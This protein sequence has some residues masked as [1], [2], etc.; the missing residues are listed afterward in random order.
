MSEDLDK[1]FSQLKNRAF[2]DNRNEVTREELERFRAKANQPVIMPA[3]ENDRLAER[4]FNEVY[5][6]SENEERIRSE[7]EKM[8]QTILN[9][10]R[11]LATT[12]ELQAKR[13]LGDLLVEREVLAELEKDLYYDISKFKDQYEKRKRDER[14]VYPKRS[15]AEIEE[16]SR[17]INELRKRKEQIDYDRLRLKENLIKIEHGDF[18]AIQRNSSN[19]LKETYAEK[20]K[21]QRFN[22]QS[23]DMG[24]LK[25]N[26]KEG[27]ERVK[28]LRVSYIYHQYK[29]NC[30]REIERSF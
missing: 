20:A 3:G 2:N 17:R 10:E 29:S 8:K 24:S 16:E 28:D 5:Y 22:S 12:K 18:K 25:K 27:S 9:I 14:L 13:E 15:Q 1:E 11:N 21:H 4:L 26:I 19:L 30:K 6:K 7:I 23:Y